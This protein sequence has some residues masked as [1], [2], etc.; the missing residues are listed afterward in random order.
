[1]LA[2]LYAYVGGGS[3]TTKKVGPIVNSQAELVYCNEGMCELLNQAFGEVFAKEDLSDIAEAKWEYSVNGGVGL[4]DIII[5]DIRVM[6]ILDKLR[7]DKAAGAGELF[8][9][10][11]SK[12][13]YQIVHLLCYL[14]T[15]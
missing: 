12:I 13:K 8:P 11:L 10:F 5:D 6:Q 15:S 3:K 1:M 7:E 9:R 2:F 4:C 14:I